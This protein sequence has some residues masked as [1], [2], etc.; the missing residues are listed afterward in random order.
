MRGKPA[1]FLPCRL[2]EPTWQPKAYQK[3]KL[4]DTCTVSE[5]GSEVIDRKIWAQRQKNDL[6]S[7]Q[8][9]KLGGLLGWGVDGGQKDWGDP[10]GRGQSQA[11]AWVVSKAFPISGELKLPLA[12]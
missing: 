2:R 1:A 6:L 9:S 5:A 8:T 10:G 12:D 11:A 4:A 7:E 3:E